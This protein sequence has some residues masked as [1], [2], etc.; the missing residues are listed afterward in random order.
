MDHR[1]CVRHIYVNFRD[2]DHRGKAL[3]DKLW[4][5]AS[6]NTEFEFDV[7]IMCA[8]QKQGMQ[9]VKGQR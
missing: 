1:V 7:L 8:V 4:V 5:A 2:S 9:L 3:K 6:A